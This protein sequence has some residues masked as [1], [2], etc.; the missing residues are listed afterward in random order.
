MSKFDWHDFFP[1]FLATMFLHNL[2]VF[3]KPIKHYLLVIHGCIRADQ[4]LTYVRWPDAF[5]VLSYPIA[6]VN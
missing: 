3:W 2:K 6:T 5:L 1:I 4:I